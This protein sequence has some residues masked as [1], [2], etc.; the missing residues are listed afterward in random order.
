[1]DQCQIDVTELSE[2]TLGEV[3]TLIGSDGDEEITAAQ[4]AE[5]AKTTCH[6]PT[7]MLTRRVSRQ[8]V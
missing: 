7:T 5:F 3:A 4:M 6:A 8:F 1:M 2:L